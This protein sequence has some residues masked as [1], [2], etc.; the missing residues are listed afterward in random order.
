MLGPTEGAFHELVTYALA[1]GEADL[2]RGAPLVDARLV[3]LRTCWRLFDA[4]IQLHDG[5]RPHHPKGPA[6]DSLLGRTG[7]ARGMGVAD[8]PAAP[9]S[10][11]PVPAGP[12]SL[13]AGDTP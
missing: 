12:G 5:A 10:A 6:A 1:A 13:A 2:V 4:D 11:D 3:D 9:D 7:T 8:D